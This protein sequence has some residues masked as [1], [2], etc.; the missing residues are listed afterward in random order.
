[1]LAGGRWSLVAELFAG[2]DTGP[3]TGAT[4]RALARARALL[5][6][7]GLVIRE[8]ARVEDLPWGPLYRVLRTMEEAG[9]V[10]R[11]YY[12]EG[13]S[14]AQFATPGAADRLR[15][16]REPEEMRGR[17]DGEDGD[18]PVAGLLTLSAVDP[19]CV[20]GGLLPWPEPPGSGRDTAPG[21]RLRRVAGARVVQ[22]DG[23]AALYVPPGGRRL[24]TLGAPEDVARALLALG[25][26]PRRGRKLFTVESIDGEPVERSPHRAALERAGFVADYKGYIHDPA[27]ARRRDG[28]AS[29]A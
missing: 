18:A 26:L 14:G 28:D 12:V 4:G 5:E 23:R 11:G 21:P 17:L 2:M 25:T 22:V 6:R 13:L 19:A 8:T 29:R 20:W 1:V 10:R 16:E 24:A 3:A 9:Q 15:S 27:A 7:H